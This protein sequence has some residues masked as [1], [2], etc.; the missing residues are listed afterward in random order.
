MNMGRLPWQ[1]YHHLCL[2][3]P[4]CEQSYPFRSLRVRIAVL[5]ATWKE[6]ETSPKNEGFQFGTQDIFVSFGALLPRRR[7]TPY[8]LR[9]DARRTSSQ[10]ASARRGR[11][12]FLNCETILLKRNF[13]PS[14]PSHPNNIYVFFPLFWVSVGV[15]SLGKDII[16]CA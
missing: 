10:S 1:R 16:I 5:R 4:L 14:S 2:D 9:H 7:T 3:V 13:L 12:N 15:D 11:H 8:R 6:T